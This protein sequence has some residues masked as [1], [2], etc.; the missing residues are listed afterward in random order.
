MIAALP[1]I[2]GAVSYGEQ[3]MAEN[4]EQTQTITRAGTQASSQGSS[5]IFTGNVT[6]L[7]LFDPKHPEAPFGASYVTFEPGA[8]SFWH[9]HPVGQHLIVTDGMGRT[10]TAD[11][12]VEELTVGDVL[13]CPPGVKH[14]HGASPTTSM[15]HIALPG[16]LPDGK[17]VEWIEEV[18]DEQYKGGK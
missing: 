5:E 11:G 3:A 9:T 17:N 4:T 2:I 13:W 8:R 1:L 7:P 10:G 12:K 15:T 6:I 14:W 16:A 18:T